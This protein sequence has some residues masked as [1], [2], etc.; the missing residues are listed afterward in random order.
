MTGEFKSSNLNSYFKNVRLGGENQSVR[1][2]INLID[3][4]SAEDTL[5]DDDSVEKIFELHRLRVNN[6]IP[7]LEETNSPR[8][9]LHDSI[10]KNKLRNYLNNSLES[11]I[12]SDVPE[13]F[14]M[15]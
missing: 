11:S 12:I 15:N 10:D 14:G 4:S 1:A 3:Q 9:S 6:A 7:S 2:N 13:D 8:S 5:K